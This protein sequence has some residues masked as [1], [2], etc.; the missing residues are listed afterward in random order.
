[1]KKLLTYLCASVLSL[2]ADA[3]EVIM[4]TS[5]GNIT[6]KLDAEKAP[7]TVKNFL[8]YV[9]K[10]H[11][12]GTTF[13]RIIPNFMI[14]GGGFKI[15]ESIHTQKKVDAPI[16]NEASNGLKNL[17]GTISMARTS[18]PD[19]ATSQFFI[20][21]VDNAMLDYPNNG[22]GYAVFGKVIKGIE[23]VDEIKKTKTGTRFLN[24]RR[25]DGTVAPNKAKDVPLEPVMIKSIRRIKS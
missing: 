6:I 19:S 20:N 2:F 13:H 18:D 21:V 3:E 22:G 17:R 23:V 25:P 10:K 11:F 9:D 15:V 5:M 4:K 7:I 1:M 12:D 16:K 14:Q 24:S 8:S